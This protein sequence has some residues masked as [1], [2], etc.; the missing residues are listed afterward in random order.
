MVPI[1]STACVSDEVT[2]SGELPPIVIGFLILFGYLAMLAIAAVSVLGGLLFVAQRFQRCPCP[3]CT[4]MYTKTRIIGK[5]TSP[6]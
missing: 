5:G 4:G 2:S 1:D 3:L 6:L